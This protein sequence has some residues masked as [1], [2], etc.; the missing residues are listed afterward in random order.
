MIVAHCCLARALE[1]SIVPQSPDCGDRFAR[2]VR[3]ESYAPFPLSTLVSG[4]YTRGLWNV[5]NLSGPKTS[6]GSRGIQR[7]RIHFVF[8]GSDLEGTTAQAISAVNE[9]L[10]RVA[11]R[12]ECALPDSPTGA[13]ARGASAL[14]TR[15][16]CPGDG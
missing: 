9:N 13:P 16:T 5:W 11:H 4:P 6:K 7:K 12:D 2:F 15:C 10:D 1:F 8:F 14:G 3:P